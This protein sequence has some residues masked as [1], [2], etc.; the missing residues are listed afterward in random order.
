MWFGGNS[1]IALALGLI[2]ILSAITILQRI[3]HVK[4]QLGN[5]Q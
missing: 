2:S 4:R 5:E 3:V 1:W